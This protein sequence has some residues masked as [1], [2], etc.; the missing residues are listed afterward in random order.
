MD[1]VPKLTVK[2]SLIQPPMTTPSATIVKSAA[3][4]PIMA[5]QAAHGQHEITAIVQAQSVSSQSAGQHQPRP[6]NPRLWTVRITVSIQ[7]DF[8]FLS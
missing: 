7:N 5:N 3:I 6:D 8:F 1:E 4:A 2:R